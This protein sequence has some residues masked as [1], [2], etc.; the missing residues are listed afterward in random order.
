VYK[1]VWK[2]R[3]QPDMPQMTKLFHGNSGYASTHQCYIIRML[4]AV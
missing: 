4:T 2:N 1:I 3:A